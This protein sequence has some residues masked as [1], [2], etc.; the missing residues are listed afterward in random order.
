MAGKVNETLWRMVRLRP[1]TV[2]RLRDLEIRIRR[3]RENGFNEVNPDE[4]DRISLDALVCELLRRDDEHRERSKSPGKK[5]RPVADFDFQHVD[6]SQI[7]T[8]E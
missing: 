5:R 8:S 3:A 6:G 7:N 4:L 2:Y 1:E